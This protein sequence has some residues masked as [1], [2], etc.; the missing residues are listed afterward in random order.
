M[1]LLKRQRL[2]VTIIKQYHLKFQ[3]MKTHY[4]L[5]FKM[6][7]LKYVSV[8]ILGHIKDNRRYDHT[9]MIFYCLHVVTDVC[10]SLNTPC[11]VRNI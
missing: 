5:T 1:L 3:E 7:Y 11:V 10:F 2:I 4:S 6:E 8:Y 9:C